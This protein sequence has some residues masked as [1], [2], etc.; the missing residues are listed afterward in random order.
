MSWEERIR[1]Q[2][3]LRRARERAYRPGEWV[4]QESFMSADEILQLAGRAGIG[5]GT[6]VLD[7]CC[8]VA[9]PGNHVA[10]ATGARLLGID[11]S[12]EALELARAG[13]E[14]LDCSFRPGSIPGLALEERF[15]VVMLLEVMLEFAEPGVLLAE[16]A[17]LLQ[18][19]GRL[20][21]TYEEGAPLEPAAMPG[22]HIHPRERMLEWLAR[23]GFEVAWEADHTASHADL[24]GRLLAA[25]REDAP[26]IGQAMGD[27]FLGELLGTHALWADW[28]S[29]RRVRKWALVAQ[30]K[31]SE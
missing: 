4:G 16:L 31:A 8:G 17:A 26:S 9:G 20:A 27:G 11:R 25:F 22:V 24:A 1:C 10:R 30:L 18:P 23:A 21:L 5:A 2:Q 12:S 28:L 6:E 19:G 15:E 7:L 14:G 3:A 13:A 29:R